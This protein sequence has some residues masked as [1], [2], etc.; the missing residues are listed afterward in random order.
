M[1]FEEYKYLAEN[2]QF[3]DSLTIFK[4]EVYVIDPCGSKKYYRKIMSEPWKYSEIYCMTFEEAKQYLHDEM[5]RIQYDK[6]CSYI[7]QIPINESIGFPYNRAWLYDHNGN[8]IDQSYCPHNINHCVKFPFRGRPE[9]AIRFRRGDIVELLDDYC[10]KSK[11][12]IVYNTPPNIE[13]AYKINKR[14]KEHGSYLDSTCD[15]YLV[16]DETLVINKVKKY[17]ISGFIEG[18][19]LRLIKPRFDPP[20]KVVKYLNQYL[21]K[22]IKEYDK[23]LFG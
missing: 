9:Y 21:Q 6:Y 3:P 19:S 2:P 13:T 22:A 20:K 5:N 4:V 15:N 18:Y 11:F 1:T 17:V 23:I 10:N 7:Y 16:I 12:V 14:L 8:L